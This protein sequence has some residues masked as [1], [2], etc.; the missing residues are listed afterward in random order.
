[1]ARNTLFVEPFRQ[2]YL[3]A[4]WGG[5]PLDDICTQ[6]SGVRSSVWRTLPDECLVVIAAD[7]DRRIVYV[8][9]GLYVLLGVLVLVRLVRC[10]IERMCK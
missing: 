4:Y 10:L 2:A 9:L 3:R 6:L 1:M 5:L 7:F 8:Y